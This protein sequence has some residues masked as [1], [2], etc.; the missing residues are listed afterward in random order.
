MAK[1]ISDP[2]QPDCLPSPERAAALIAGR[3]T[4]NSFRPELPPRSLI[5]R[6]ISL[7]RWA[8]NHHLTEPW[9]FYLIGPRTR[10]GIVALNAEL[11]AAGKGAEAAEAKRSRWSAIP[12]WLAVTCNRS[13][14]GLRQ[15]EDYAACACA[16]QNLS[17]YLWSEG[18]GTKWTTGAVTREARFYDLLWIDPGQEEVVGLIWYGYPAESPR[19]HRSG[20]DV[21]LVDLP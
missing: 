1:E 16:I 2:V 15:R 11:V 8:P 17:L 20:V 4:I 9:N 21:A 5:R 12:G 13:D 6:G 7:A 10:D 3:R 14:D 18:V 19:T